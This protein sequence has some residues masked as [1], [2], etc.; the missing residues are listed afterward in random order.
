MALHKT[1]KAKKQYPNKFDLYPSFADKF[2]IWYDS[3]L[4]CYKVTHYSRFGFRGQWNQH[5]VRSNGFAPNSILR[6][7]EWTYTG[8]GKDFDNEI[9]ALEFAKAK[10]KERKMDNAIFLLKLN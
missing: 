7:N 3:N 8:K 9:A 1:K 4:K 6:R 10:A 2:L 5:G